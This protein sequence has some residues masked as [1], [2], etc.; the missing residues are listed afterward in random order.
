MKEDEDQDI[1]TIPYDASQQEQVAIPRE[2][3]FG[4][5]EREPYD[6]RLS[7]LNANRTREER[8]HEELVPVKW[9]SSKIRLMR[10][11][12]GEDRIS[13]TKQTS[14]VP[15]DHQAHSNGSNPPTPTAGIVRACSNCNT[16]KTPLWR[17]GPQGPKVT[18]QKKIGFLATKIFVAESIKIVAKTFS[19]EK[20]SLLK[21]RHVKYW[22]RNS[23]VVA[24]SLCCSNAASFS[25]LL[26]WTKFSLLKVEVFRGIWL[27]VQISIYHSIYCTHF[28]VSLQCLWNK[29]NEGKACDESGGSS[30][31]GGWWAGPSR[32]CTTT[33]ESG[34]GE[35][36]SRPHGSF[37]ETVQDCRRPFE[38]D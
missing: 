27:K 32:Y 6:H 3:L 23:E 21:V 1:S 14:Q 25:S 37:Q 31:G 18:L 2:Q 7:I 20:L 19:N 38:R 9:M 11:M 8:A 35:I 33:R 34:E 5:Q 13:L 24:E 29:A 36:R 15:Q 12:M 30:G 16:T 4:Q 26:S 17:S 10:K 22:Q 28:A